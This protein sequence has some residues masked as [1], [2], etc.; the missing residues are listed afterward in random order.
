MK[1]GLVHGVICGALLGP[2]L[3]AGNPDFPVYREYSQPIAIYD[4][5][6]HL[7]P[8][9]NV[10]VDVAAVK[11]MRDGKAQEALLGRE[12]LWDLT[13]SDR[14]SVLETPAPLPP[15]PIARGDDG[16][17]RKG[18]AD[19]NWLAQSL[20]LPSLG[21]SHSNAAMHAMSS[22]K[23]SAWGWLADEIARN[24]ELEFS[25][26][27]LLRAEAEALR[28]HVGGSAELENRLGATA[29]RAIEY[30]P[31]T[32]EMTTAQRSAMIRDMEKEKVTVGTEPS[33]L[34]GVVN[35]S[36]S[37]FSGEQA[38]RTEM[39]QTRQMLADL[40]GPARPEFPSLRETLGG[41]EGAARGDPDG[42]KP[43]VTPA[44]QSERPTL[45][46]STRRASGGGLNLPTAS[47]FADAARGPATA[48]GAAA[49]KTDWSQ[50]GLSGDWAGGGPRGWG[51]PPSQP[52]PAGRP[53]LQ[54]PSPTR[55]IQFDS[56]YK[57]AWH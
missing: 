36:T 41:T 4:A 6:G 18:T 56:G 10:A 23:D 17:R 33:G 38:A 27:D 22:G 35:P 57:P 44:R 32:D 46:F 21:Q 2:A 19:D 31:T 39:A 25:E 7:T 40:A 12:T 8:A 5:S 28:Q 16:R 14:E 1:I 20:S 49:W 52:T 24:E 47:P 15:M 26:E 42:R 54:P 51:Q 55:A 37:V 30:M 43:D 29:E 3:G 53:G 45:D 34:A 48:G 13:F 11:Q 9:G 50:P